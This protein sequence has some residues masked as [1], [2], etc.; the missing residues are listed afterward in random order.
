MKFSIITVSYNAKDKLRET[1]E[2]VAAQ[3]CTDYEVIVKDGGSTDGSTDFLKET[4]EAGD[5]SDSADFLRK[6]Q[7]ARDDGA[8]SPADFRGEPRKDGNE[9]SQERTEENVRWRE[10]LGRVRFLEGKDNGIYDAMNRAMLQARGEFILFLNCGDLLAD[11]EVLAR[12]AKA[13]ESQAGEQTGKARAGEPHAAEAVRRLVLYG[14]TFSRKSGVTI[15]SPPRITGFTCYRNIPCHQS[16]FYSAMLCREKP[17]DLRYRIRADYDHFLWCFYQGGA[18]FVRLDF[19]VSSYEGGGY[20][21]S[22]ENRESD[23][24]EHREITSLYMRKGELFR[25]RAAMAFTLAPLRRRM[26]DSR[27]FSGLYHG[28]KDMAYQRKKL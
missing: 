20:S 5:D 17:F 4:R 24:R 6:T 19:P 16:C 26:A 3:T 8:D 23:R 21:E 1:L 2:S 22:R 13:A 7:K 28:I 11:R 10:L 27:L 18:E 14:D 25:Y 12:A 9:D 15:A